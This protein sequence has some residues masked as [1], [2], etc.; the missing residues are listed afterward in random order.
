MQHVSAIDTA[1]LAPFSFVIFMGAMAAMA[2]MS[3]HVDG[4]HRDES[5]RTREPVAAVAP[6]QTAAGFAR[7]AGPQ[8]L[9][10]H[11]GAKASAGGNSTARRP[12][13]G[14]TVSWTPS[15]A[16]EATAGRVFP[17]MSGVGV[18][19][20]ETPLRAPDPYF[21][22]PSSILLDALSAPFAYLTG[23]NPPVAGEGHASDGVPEA[24]P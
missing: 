2:M 12:M 22:H 11:P 14:A 5:R 20:M 13:T 9:R 15:R 4:T 23:E 8:V 3:S 16:G 18:M 19:I 7:A 17:P 10:P 6:V 24:A 1:R 21:V